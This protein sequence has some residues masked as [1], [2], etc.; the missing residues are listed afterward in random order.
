M[1]HEMTRASAV[2]LRQA[3]IGEASK[4]E[5]REG[6]NNPVTDGDMLSH[7]VRPRE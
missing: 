7:K 5:T 6:A 3:D 1:N 2:P 4:G